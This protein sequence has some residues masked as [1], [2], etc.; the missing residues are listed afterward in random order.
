MLSVVVCNA[1]GG[2]AGRQP[3]A[4][5]RGVGTLPAIGNVDGRRAGGRTRGRSGGR[6]CTA[7]QSCY[8][9]LWRHLL[10]WIT[11]PVQLRSIQLQDRQICQDS[12]NCSLQCNTDGLHVGWTVF[13]LSLVWFAVL[14]L[15]RWRGTVV[16]RRSV[17]GEPSLPHAPL[18]ADG[19]PLI[20]VNRPLQVSQLSLSSLQGR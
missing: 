4:W 5:E 6:H 9:P 19:W 13:A 20:W 12:S 14:L 7:G 17:T 18:A 16:E 15:G 3:E 11:L 1:V 2:R 8:V 10:N